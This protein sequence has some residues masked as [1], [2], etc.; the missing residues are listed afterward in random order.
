MADKLR[1]LYVFCNGKNR[2]NASG[3]LA[4]YLYHSTIH[5]LTGLLTAKYKISSANRL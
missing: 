2:E 4:I 1:I 5:A 3:M